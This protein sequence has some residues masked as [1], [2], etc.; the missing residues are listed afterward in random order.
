MIS[1]YIVKNAYNGISRANF[2]LDKQHNINELEESIASQ[3]VKDK[4]IGEAKFLRAYYLFSFGRAI[5]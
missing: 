4:F 1:F 3:E 5:W 2:I